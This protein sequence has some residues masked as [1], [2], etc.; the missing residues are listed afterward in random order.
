MRDTPRTAWV[1]VFVLMLVLG[2]LWLLV[3]VDAISFAYQ[4]LGLSAEEALLLLLG[5]LLGS[6]IDV[7][8]ARIRSEQKVVPQAVTVFGVRYSVPVQVGGTTVIALNVGG[9]L[10]PTAFSFWLMAHTGLWWKSAVAA[11]AVAVVVHL[12]ARPVDG[13]GIVVPALVPPLVAAGIAY[14][15][16]GMHAA[17]IAY[18]AGT[19]GTLVGADISNLY[20][21]SETGAGVASIGGAGTFDAV[22][23][24]GVGAVLLD[25][26]L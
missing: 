6:R 9:C 18:V 13:V 8:V 4:R 24:S 2:V 11:L 16:A 12:I 17:P 20:R 5:S 14:A 7:P 10:I 26:L 21:I 15:I 23:L 19:I 3:Y 25:A 22:F 1:F